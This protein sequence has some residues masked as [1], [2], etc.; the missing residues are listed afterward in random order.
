MYIGIFWIYED[1][2]YTYTQKAVK[3][4]QDVEIGHVD[5]W[6]SLR[7]KHKELKE[8]PYDCIPRGRVLLKDDKSIVYSSKEIIND[9]RKRALISDV[10]KLNESTEF[11]YDEHYS[12]IIDLGFEEL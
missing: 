6:D 11:K 4:T 12:Q 9:S 2:I 5:Y 10:F 3:A 1:S 8:Y 7:Q